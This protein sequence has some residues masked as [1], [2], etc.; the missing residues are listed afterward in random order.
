MGF[1]ANHLSRD[2]GSGKTVSSANAGGFWYHW[3]CECQLRRRSAIGTE[4]DS[5]LL[6]KQRTDS[7]RGHPNSVWGHNS[8]ETAQ[9]P[10]LWDVQ[11]PPFALVSGR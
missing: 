7:L 1:R 3:L 4:Q 11:G 8:L 10:G 5:G 9:I 2:P 6:S